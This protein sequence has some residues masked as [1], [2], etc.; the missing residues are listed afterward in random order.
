MKDLSLITITR[1]D[2][3]LL[4]VAQTSIN[5]QSA[6]SRIEH[7]IVDSSDLPII[8]NEPD[9]RVIRMEPRGVYAALNE[10]LRASSGKILGM[11]HG[12]DRFFSPDV[13]ET[14]MKL[15]DHDPELDFV[16]GDLV[17]EKTSTHTIMRRYDSGLF[18]PE[19]LTVGFAP[20]HPTLFMRRRVFEK[21][22]FY[23]ETYR[24]AGDFEMWL[25]LFNPEHAFKWQHIPMVMVAMSHG[26]M[27]SLLKNQLT[28]NP[29]E[30]L[31]ALRRNNLP[32]NVFRLFKRINYL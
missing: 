26:G 30:K 32:A 13:V 28:V 31:R 5:W 3:P 21:V 18:H 10:G 6:R 17:Y 4:R 27:S 24:V 16:F 1:N 15:F 25:R 12:N 7:I 22:G 29:V 14:V 2:G 8:V 20:A 11:L 19:L 9:V 23:D